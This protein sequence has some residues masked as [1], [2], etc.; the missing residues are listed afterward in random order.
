MPTAAPIAIAPRTIS[1]LPV[2]P[3]LA[4]PTGFPYYLPKIR[5]LLT[6]EYIL[7][8]L[9]LAII[10]PDKKCDYLLLWPGVILNSLR[11]QIRL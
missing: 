9:V 11:V 8:A 4:D 6:P 7:G 3:A 10:G 2:H 5:V 1:T